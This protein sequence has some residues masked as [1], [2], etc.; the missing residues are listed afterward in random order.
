M[1]TNGKTTGICLSCLGENGNHLAN[2]NGQ[3]GKI[4]P[5]HP[6]VVVA[7]KSKHVWML[8]RA[9]DGAQIATQQAAIVYCSDD[10]SNV[11]KMPFAK[12]T[13]WLSEKD[14]AAAMAQ[15]ARADYDAAAKSG[16]VL[17]EFGIEERDGESMLIDARPDF[18]AKLNAA[19]LA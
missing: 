11:S 18:G 12:M 6:Y 7:L 17:M 9:S 19:R 8:F 4:D 16:A 14:A 10:P 15:I 5:P 13:G 1:R 3:A 2:C